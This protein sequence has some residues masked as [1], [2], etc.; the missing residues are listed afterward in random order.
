MSQKVGMEMKQKKK[1]E[2]VHKTRRERYG[3]FEAVAVH[4]DS[5]GL[6]PSGLSLESIP[7]NTSVSKIRHTYSTQRLVAAWLA[8][9]TD[10]WTV[11]RS[12]R[13]YIFLSSAEPQ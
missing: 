5:I 2:L 8:Y 1:R 6:G 4:K 11:L 3:R 12:L 9:S 7:T 10:C 13:L